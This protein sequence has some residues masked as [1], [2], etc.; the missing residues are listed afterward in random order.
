MKLLF[1][2]IDGTTADLITHYFTWYNGMYNIDYRLKDSSEFDSWDFEDYICRQNKNTSKEIESKRIYTIFSSE[3]FWETE[4]FFQNAFETIKY[5]DKNY[6]TYFLT[7]PSF[8]SPFFFNERV[9]WVKKN[10][11]FFDYHKLI[12]SENKSIFK[13]GILIDDRPDNLE[14]F[15]GKTIK[16]NYKY[17]EKTK[18]DANFFSRDWYTVPSLL[19]KLC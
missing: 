16:V 14:Y 18:S 15:N 12:F 10:L 4:P 9:K 2:D 5:L 19:E 8:N 1:I 13:E 11:P 6:D 3:T 7:S 17:N